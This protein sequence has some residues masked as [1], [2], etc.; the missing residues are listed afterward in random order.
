MNAATTNSV[1]VSAR[2][3]C[4]RGGLGGCTALHRTI[5]GVPVVGVKPGD[6]VQPPK[7]QVPA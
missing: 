7:P 2:L 3:T 5:V 4:V 6:A 1:A